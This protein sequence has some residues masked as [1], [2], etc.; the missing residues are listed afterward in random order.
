MIVLALVST[1]A[2]AQTTFLTGTTTA[3]VPRGSNMTCVWTAPSPT[4][5]PIP[6]P[7][8]TPSGSCVN[9]TAPTANATLS[10]TVTVTVSENCASG[11]FNRLYVGNQSFDFTGTSYQLNTAQIPN[12]AYSL[13]LIDWSSNGLTK[14]GSAPS[15]PV[16]ISNSG[17]SSPTPTPTAT[18]TPVSG[19]A[20]I[21][22]AK[23]FLATLGV[24]THIITGRMTDTQVENGLNYLGVYNIRDDATCFL[25]A[26]SDG[27]SVQ[28]L[29]AVHSA[30]GAMVDELP[31]TFLPPNSMPAT[32]TML[33][34]LANA[35][36]LLQIEGP[37][38]PNNNNF[39]SDQGNGCNGSTALGCENYQAA[40]FAMARNM[41]DPNSICTG[42]GTANN[43]CGGTMLCCTGV[44]QGTC[45][46]LK[47]YEVTSL[48]EPG[49]E[50][51][52][53]GIQF[54]T[55]TSGLADSVPAGV[56][57]SDSANDHNYVQGNGG[58]GS[59]LIDNHARYAGTVNRTGPYAGDWD[60]YGEQWGT[61]WGH[62]FS[63]GSTGQFDRRK[64]TTETG[65]NANG[66][67]SPV[68]VGKVLTDLVLDQ[69]P[70]QL[71]FERTFLYQLVDDSQDEG[72]G[73]FT[74]NGNEGDAGNARPAAAYLHN[75][76]TILADSNGSFTPSAP[77]GFSVTVPA[78]STQ[79]SNYP[80]T[81]YY[82][83]MQKTNGTYWLVIWGEAFAS[84]T[85]DNVTVNFGSAVN[86][87]VYDITQ[88][89]A[90]IST[91]TTPNTSLSI[92]VTDHAIVVEW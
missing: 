82:Q 64:Q 85:V 43:S 67:V 16:T 87:S 47:G 4:P 60:L 20:P 52:N 21:V 84:E 81:A 63:S 26:N 19:G 68:M 32:Q 51:D 40:L 3:D 44:D 62:G 30:T 23:S 33:E 10:G 54:L 73:L 58:A 46:S 27:G 88:G 22:S 65:W 50:P 37:N 77:A 80:T 79:D 13:G 41:T 53:A 91:S 78:D 45:P 18:P 66:S 71:G 17:G 25:S 24:D 59:T 83:L 14:E 70:A 15:V 38:E 56:S 6:S 36:A 12:G 90:P 28:D 57:L 75:L 42:A 9:I 49:F 39:T 89:T 34:D 2:S 92:G 8:P 86:E 11:A 76:T 7:S 74:A 5:T 61:T 48:T 29:I 72:W 1:T 35:G 31:V 69:Q 55:T